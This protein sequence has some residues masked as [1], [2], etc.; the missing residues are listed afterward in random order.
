MNLNTKTTK[1]LTDLVAEHPDL[2][3][4]ERRY[5][6]PPVLKGYPWNPAFIHKVTDLLLRNLHSDI[7]LYYR[8]NGQSEAKSL[9]FFNMFVYDSMKPILFKRLTS[10]SI[11]FMGIIASQFDFIIVSTIHMILENRYKQYIAANSKTHEQLI[12]VTAAEIAIVLTTPT[13]VLLNLVYPT[14]SPSESEWI[15]EY[16]AESPGFRLGGFG[17]RVIQYD[18]LLREY[19][20]GIVVSLSG[21]KRKNRTYR[22]KRNNKSRKNK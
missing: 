2:D 18:T 5:L 7:T 17:E 11:N 1:H 19:E 20:P 9:Q 22:R 14:L 8:V 4:P 15:R 12:G 21:G 16:M 13:T 3:F 10:I 6:L